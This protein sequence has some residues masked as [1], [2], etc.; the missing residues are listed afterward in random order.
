M[1]ELSYTSWYKFFKN[2]PI[3]LDLKLRNSKFKALEKNTAVS[4]QCIY[5]MMVNLQ[6]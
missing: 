3:S 1:N 2:I 6:N 4:A 5:C